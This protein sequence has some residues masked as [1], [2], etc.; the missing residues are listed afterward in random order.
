MFLSCWKF[1]QAYRPSFCEIV[2]ELDSMKEDDSFQ[3]GQYAY[4]TDDAEF[5]KGYLKI[6]PNKED[7]SGDGYQYVDS[8]RGSLKSL[9]PITPNIQKVS[10]LLSRST[11]FPVQLYN[12]KKLPS[13][14]LTTPPHRI[15]VDDDD[16]DDSLE[17]SYDY[18]THVPTPP[19]IIQQSAPDNI[20]EDSYEYVLPS[21]SQSAS[22]I[23]TIHIQSFSD[24]IE[25][26]DDDNEYVNTSPLLLSRSAPDT[27][28]VDTYDY[29]LP[30]S[31]S[32]TGSTLIPMVNIQSKGIE[33]DTEYVN[34]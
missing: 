31:Q 21:F 20:D 3:E 26:D 34:V 7:I 15:V 5:S 29:V 11:T 28:D 22:P 2:L 30:L 19:L 1:K 24:R 8:T 13:S 6:L 10:P 4:I 14:P 25:P 33:P 27:H 12:K 18:V 17:E 16:D 32:S 9:S 23:P